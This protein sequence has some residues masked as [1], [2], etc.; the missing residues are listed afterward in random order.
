M[1]EKIIEVDTSEITGKEKKITWKGYIPFIRNVVVVV[2]VIVIM[3]IN[4]RKSDCNIV[5]MI[6]FAIIGISCMIEIGFKIDKLFEKGK[7]L[8]K[9]VIN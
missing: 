1:E 7:D 9:D 8:Y 5:A 6:F 4:L 2:G 3:L